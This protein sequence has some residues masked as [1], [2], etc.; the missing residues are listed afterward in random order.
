[1]VDA[2][3]EGGVQAVPIH[4]NVVKAARSHGG[5]ND[6]LDAYRL[7]GLL[8]TDG[9]RFEPLVV[10]KRACSEQI[11]STCELNSGSQNVIQSKHL[12]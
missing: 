9:D 3:L 5:R 8:R 7:A 1:V 6:A 11:Y 10:A 4:P 2:F 12:A